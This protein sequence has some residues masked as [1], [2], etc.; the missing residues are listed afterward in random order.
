MA[1]KSGKNVA[2]GWLREKFLS[3]ILAAHTVAMCMLGCALGF[4]LRGVPGFAEVDQGLAG[5]ILV[6][7]GLLALGSLYAVGLRVDSTLGKGLRAERRVGDLIE[8][9]VTQPGCAFAHDVKESLGGSEHVDH[10]VMTPAGVW[11]VEAKWSRLRKRQLRKALRQVA[12]NVRQVR[13]HLDTSLPVRGALV[14][15]GAS[16]ELL[17]RNHEWDGEPVKFYGS[18][19]FWRLLR[20]EREQHSA[21]G[22][23]ETKRVERVVW[24]L[25]SIRYVDS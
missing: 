11:V 17:D 9:A 12:G 22:S 21:I 1:E 5:W 19:T 18:K 24:G 15:A 6:G 4:L 14:I 20:Q 16:E 13:T 10:I 3:R 23:P 8:H 7:T 25:G 2:G